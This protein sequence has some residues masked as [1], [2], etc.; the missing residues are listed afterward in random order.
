MNPT[1]V[2]WTPQP[3]KWLAALAAFAIATLSCGE[4]GETIPLHVA[5]KNG[6]AKVTARACG[7]CTGDT[8]IVTV[9]KKTKA[10]LRLAMAPGTFFSSTNGRGQTM[11]G[12]FIRG[13]LTEGWR[14]W[15]GDKI[16]L[17]DNEPRDYVVVAFC[18]DHRK[19][20]QPP[21]QKLAVGPPDVAAARL[22]GAGKNDADLTHH[23]MQAAIW[24]YRVGA[25]DG[26]IA[27]R[28]R[29][30]TRHDLQAARAL[31]ARMPPVRSK[32]PPLSSSP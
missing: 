3:L 12:L 24:M 16:E 7:G 13:E 21:G 6:A 30:A 10:P 8:V 22:F 5:A 26:E 25:K 1:H 28:F 23:A 27:G 14:L 31:V 17:W 32:T 18:L 9:Q 29:A 15:P 11:T 4:A 20:S 19:D 2:S